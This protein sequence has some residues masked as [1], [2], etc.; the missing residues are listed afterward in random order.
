MLHC[1]VQDS[2][3]VSVA[4]FV[5]TEDVYNRDMCLLEQFGKVGHLRNR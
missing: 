2:V 3:F 5:Q 1:D 4:L